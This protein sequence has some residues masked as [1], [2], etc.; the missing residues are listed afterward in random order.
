MKLPKSYKE[1]SV[2]K[3]QELFPT[4]QKV[5]TEQDDDKK[6][7]FQKELCKILGYPID[8]L[9]IG[10]QAKAIK[11]ISF[12]KS[13]EYK[14][15]YK[16]L[17]IKGK[18]YKAEN[19]INKLLTSQYISIKTIIQDGEVIPH[20]ADLAPLCYKRFK[21]KH[22]YMEGKVQHTKY[23]TFVYDASNHTEL[24]EWFKTAPCNKVLPLVF[25]CSM[26]FK[27]WIQS[28]EAYLNS[29]RIIKEREKEIRELL[30][31]GNFLNIGAGT[32]PLMN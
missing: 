2:E 18:L 32:P 11:R 21:W 1:I 3:Y 8:H 12:L 23:F 26:V 28:T 7:E 17:W 10:E 29:Q 24:S 27:H 19:D 9:T 25:F 13:N 4:L 15:V 30:L 31:E 22:K 5:L 14:L 16:Y 6:H 20:L